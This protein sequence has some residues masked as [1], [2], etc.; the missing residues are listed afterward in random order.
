[1]TR[2]R[3]PSAAACHR[4]DSPRVPSVVAGERAV[5]VEQDGRRRRRGHRSRPP[6]ACRPGGGGSGARVPDPSFEDGDARVAATRKTTPGYRQF[7]KRAV[8]LGGGDPHRY[9]LADA[10]LIKENH[11]AI[12]GL[13]TCIERA[14][15]RASFT[16]TVEV[17]T[18]AQAERAAEAEADIL[19]LDNMT[20]ADAAACVDAL[21]ADVTVE[22]SGGI[23]PETAPA[24]AATG[25]DVVSMGSLVY[26]A[27]W[28]DTSLLVES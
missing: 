4:P 1:M 17:E 16:A 23:T 25:V 20:P 11:V 24:Y 28:L 7:E 18:V 14:R 8:R 6:T 9:S 22:A 3:G 5:A 19:L 12:A 21:D 26:D 10:V 15:R 2:R 27:G 13:E